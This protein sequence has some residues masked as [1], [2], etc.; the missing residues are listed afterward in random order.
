MSEAKVASSSSRQEPRAA[1]SSDPGPR[2][3]RRAYSS[4]QLIEWGS[5]VDLTRGG[6]GAA[7]DYDFISTKAV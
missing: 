2:L 1:P 7:G 5:L 6:S 4:P 3:P